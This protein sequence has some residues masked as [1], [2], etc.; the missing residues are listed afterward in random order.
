[1]GGD[2]PDL[3]SYC[4]PVDDGAAPNPFWGTCTLVICKPKIRKVAKVGDW[5]VGTGSHNSPL[6]D[7]ATKVVYAMRVT[8]KLTMQKYNVRTQQVLKEKVPDWENTDLRR[9]VGDSIYDFT[10]FPYVI[11]KSVHDEGNRARDLSGKYALLSTH[12]YY[13]GDHPVELPSTLH[14]VIK[15]GQG[16]KRLKDH[17]VV[18][19]FIAWI[20]GL[21]H[22]PNSLLGDPQYKDLKKRCILDAEEDE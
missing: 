13:F 4:I 14:G 5:V 9:R 6:G 2:V 15:A 11:R 17:G 1:V 10:V 19:R 7:I 18:T 8:E 20:D 16:H 21:G 12:F 3:F 22:K